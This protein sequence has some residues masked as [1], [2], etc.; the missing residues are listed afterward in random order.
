MQKKRSMID[1]FF[2]ICLFCLYA[3]G[4][5]FL[6]VIGANVYQRGVETAETNY[7]SRTSLLYITEK[8][9]QN[10]A[11]DAIELRTM[12]GNDAL[13][14]L[15]EVNDFKLETWIYVENDY[16]CEVMLTEGVELIPNIGQQIMPIKS[17]DLAFDDDL[18]SIE[19]TDS[20]NEIHSTSLFLD[21][22]D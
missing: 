7:N 11:V 20:N 18:M 17:L 8:A 10:N 6:S 19:I 1:V 4:A 14:I 13:V 3:L 9:R 16:L 21:C 2:V 5:L 22:V 15:S 12:N